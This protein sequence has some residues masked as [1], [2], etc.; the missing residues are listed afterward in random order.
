MFDVSVNQGFSGPWLH[1]LSSRPLGVSAC[2]HAPEAPPARADSIFKVTMLPGDGVGPE[3][4]TAVKEIFK[5]IVSGTTSGSFAVFILV[6]ANNVVTTINIYFKN[7]TTLSSQG[8]RQYYCG[9]TAYQGPWGTW[10][11][12][13]GLGWLQSCPGQITP[14]LP[15]A[16]PLLVCLFI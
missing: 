4:M 14:S 12:S 13:S 9:G 2:L 16:P 8:Y 6:A 7:M 5:V 1:Q 15:F 10:A 3:L 11:D